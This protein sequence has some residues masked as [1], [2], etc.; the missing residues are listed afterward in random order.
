MNST[1]AKLRIVPAMEVT[2]GAFNPIYYAAVTDTEVT[3]RRRTL[4][5]MASSAIVM[6]PLSRRIRRWTRWW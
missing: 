3:P 4:Q 2:E 5:H 1:S 6:P